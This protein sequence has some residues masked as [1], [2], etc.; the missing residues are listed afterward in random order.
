[1]GAAGESSG[2]VLDMM[3]RLLET[4]Y[5]VE[6]GA[7]L[8]NSALLYQNCALLHPTLDVCDIDLY[9]GKCSFYKAG[10]ARSYVKREGQVEEIRQDNLPLGFFEKLGLEA[11]EKRLMDGDYLIMVSDGV[12]EVLMNGQYEELFH[13]T[14]AEMREQNPQVIAEKLLQLIIRLSGG[15]IC[16][17]MTI[18]VAGIWEKAAMA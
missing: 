16:D 6:T 5:S 15:H 17:D 8:V 12:T 2:W 9:R 4:G 11:R 14:L 13:S 18:L 10:G 3:E 1:G 7:D